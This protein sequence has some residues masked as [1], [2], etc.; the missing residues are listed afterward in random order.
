M[1]GLTPEDGILG[2]KTKTEDKPSSKGD[3]G[4]S[5]LCP[6]CRSRRVWRDAKRYTP[7]GFEIQRWSCRDC[8]V[9]FSD[10][11]DTQRAKEAMNRAV[12]T[13][14]SKSLKIA[15]RIVTTRQICV[16]ETKNL[17]AEQQKTEVLRRSDTSCNQRKNR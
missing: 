2:N 15:D 14:D 12:E 1:A 5:P 8:G 3:V 13:V 6:K 16:T 9:R 17:E 7:Q 4:S 10:P 11:S